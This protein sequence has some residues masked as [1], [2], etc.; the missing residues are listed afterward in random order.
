MPSKGGA[1]YH[2]TKSSPQEPSTK[3]DKRRDE[4]EVDYKQL[5]GASVT[6]ATAGARESC[7]SGRKGTVLKVLLVLTLFSVGI[8]VGFIIHRS[9]H[10]RHPHHVATHQDVTVR[11]PPHCVQVHS[12][13]DVTVWCVD[14]F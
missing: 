13:N 12:T 9:A 14:E 5:D 6:S 8:I 2:R 3:W 4:I 1:G 7:F 11:S 10:H